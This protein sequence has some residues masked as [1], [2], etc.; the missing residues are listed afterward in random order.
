MWATERLVARFVAPIAVA[1]VALPAAVAQAQ[2]QAPSGKSPVT[3][4]DIARAT[5]SQPT[6][7]D[8]DIEAARRKHRM[9]S[10]EE[11]A[12]VPVPSAP[13]I[14][15]LPQPQS[16]GK[17]DLGAIAG[18]F[19]AMGAPDPAKAGM[20]VGPTLLVFVS[21]SMPEVSPLWRIRSM[22]PADL[23]PSALTRTVLRYSRASMPTVD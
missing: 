12:R 5:R 9:P 10:D 19:D 20:A 23:S 11:L 4:A 14:D 2:G 1:L 6:I 16:Q 7:T 8:K 22:M 18:G 13:R 17:I 15:A 3:E 21:F